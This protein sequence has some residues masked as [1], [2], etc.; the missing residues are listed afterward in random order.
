MSQDFSD[1]LYCIIFGSFWYLYDFANGLGAQLSVRIRTGICTKR[2]GSGSNSVIK[3]QIQNQFFQKSGSRSNPLSGCNW[4]TR[5]RY[6]PSGKA[7]GSRIQ[8]S[9]RNGSFRKTGFGSDPADKTGYG[10]KFAPKSG[11]PIQSFRRNESVC[12]PFKRSTNGSSL[13]QNVPE[14]FTI[15]IS[16]EFTL[17]SVLDFLDI[18]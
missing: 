11:L 7:R 9:G 3:K 14:I 6:N 5:F 13:I 2:Q 15:L 16:C 12:Y 17:H 18:Q 10:S 8:T 4:I 1:T